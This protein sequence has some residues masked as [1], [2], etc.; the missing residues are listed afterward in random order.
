MTSILSKFLIFFIITLYSF[1]LPE[2]DIM[3]LFSTDTIEQS[4]LLVIEQEVKVESI[5]PV[6]LRD[7]YSRRAMNYIYAQLFKI[8][9]FGRVVPYLLSEYRY[10][11]EM[12]MYCKLKDDIFF[13]NGDRITSQDVKDSIETFLEKGYMNDI[14][15]GIKEIKVLNDKE[16]LILL[17]YPDTELELGLT[18]PLM[19]ITKRI[20]NKPISSGRYG[21]KE[22]TKDK[23]ILNRNE[24]Y[25]DKTLPFETIEIR[26]ELNAYQRVINSLNLP[27]YY[28]YDL[29][30]EDIETVYKIGGTKDKEIV[31]D[32]V[33]DVISLVFGNNKNF[34][35]EDRM[36]LESLLNRETS[37]I[38]PQKMLDVKLSKLEKRYDT[39][40]AIKLLKKS[41]ILHEKIKLM[42][43]NTIHNRT[44]AQYVAHDLN[45]KGLDIEIEIYNLDKF[46]EKLRSKNYDIAL[47]NITINM[48]YPVT[49]LEKSIVGEFVDPELEDSILTFVN[50]FKEETDRKH[51]ERIVDKLFYLVYSSRYFIPLA[52][53][54]LY[55]L[56]TT[57]F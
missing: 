45:E 11:D 29:Y 12:E 2:D 49:S 6:L 56:K 47:F 27:N 40:K 8:D 14:Y 3:K 30:N 1:A 31:E 5:D 35:L 9:E 25:S 21:I 7:S 36:A 52:H 57:S 42:C 55:T 43:L 41:G 54:Q 46:F 17:N 28:S 19:S 22:F 24:Y 38:F 48:V 44:F 34:S 23:L 15:E 18:N 20:D 50:I 4:T 39:E 32:S 13:S 26:G 37:T 53:R 10:N 16:F 51:R 33:F